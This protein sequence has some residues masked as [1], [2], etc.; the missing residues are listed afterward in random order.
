MQNYLK[1][2]RK[3]PL[4]LDTPKWLFTSRPGYLAHAKKSLKMTKKIVIC[5]TSYESH[6]FFHEFAV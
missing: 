4:F 6:T 1:S 5:T 2:T 3:N